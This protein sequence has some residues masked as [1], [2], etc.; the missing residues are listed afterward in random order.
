MCFEACIAKKTRRHDFPAS[1]KH[2]GKVYSHDLAE[3]LNLAGLGAQLDKDSMINPQ[4][5]ENW[6]VIKAWRVDSR[7]ET[8]GLSGKDMVESLNAPDGVLPWIQL[9]W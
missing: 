8:S 9:H 6:S 1:V 3:L 7:Y 4:L 5:A 2:A